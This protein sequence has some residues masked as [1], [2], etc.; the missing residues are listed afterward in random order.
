MKKII[1]L[2]IGIINLLSCEEVIDVDVPETSPRLV[3]DASIERQFDEDENFIG[4][5]AFVNLSLTTPFFSETPIFVNNAQVLI[6]N[7]NSNEVFDLVLVSSQGDFEIQDPTFEIF[8]NVEYTLRVLY[9]NEVYEAKEI[10]SFST[11]FTSI[12]QIEN[13]NNAFDEDD[14]IVDFSFDDLEGQRNYYFLYLDDSNIAPITDEFFTDG[15]EIKFTYFFDDTVS[16]TPIFK[17]YGSNKRLDSFL[18][19]INTL[20]TGDANGPFGTVPFTARGNIINKTN[21][22]NF[23]FGYFRVSEVYFASTQLFE[24]DNFVTAIED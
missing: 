10:L 19:A 7:T 16:L 14:I 13:D 21:Q 2:L 23:P 6:I 20:S 18:N 9:N 17:L 24:N 3:I 15:E 12:D 4:D 11:P 1:C 22:G 5:K 8:N